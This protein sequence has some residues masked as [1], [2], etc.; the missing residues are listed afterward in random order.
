MTSPITEV[1]AAPSDAALAHFQA[2]QAED[3]DFVL[4]DV[5]S[6]TLYAR[7]HVPGAVNL[8]HGRITRHR[9]SKFPEGMTFVVYCAGPHCKGADRAAIRLA[10]L[11]LPVKRIHG[12][13]AGWIDEGFALV[14]GN[15]E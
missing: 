9:M 12:G 8:P 6:P 10:G 4:F 15:P 5:R 13:I 11:G 2:L 14:T 3:R 7:G 1:P